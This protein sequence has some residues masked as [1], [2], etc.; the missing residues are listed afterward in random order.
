MCQGLDQALGGEEKSVFLHLPSFLLSLLQ[1]NQLS[2]FP[3]KVCPQRNHFPQEHG[4]GQ[5]VE[6]REAVLA[7][8]PPRRKSPK[9]WVFGAGWSPGL[10][11]SVLAERRGTL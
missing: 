6:S 5:V 10:P 2:F 4:Q 3:G 7:L 9:L 1:K 8:V 11:V